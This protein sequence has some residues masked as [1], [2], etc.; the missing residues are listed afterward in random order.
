M[1]ISI[2]NYD[3]FKREYQKI[4]REFQF[5]PKEDQRARDILFKMIQSKKRHWKVEEILEEF[6]RKI[7]ENNA[8]LIYGCGPSLEDSVE[9][10]IASQG[11]SIFKRFINLAADGASVFLRERELPLEGIFTDL[12]G[13]TEKE[14]TYGEYLIVHAHGDNIDKLKSFKSHIIE[15]KNVIATTQVEPKLGVFNPGGFTDGDRILYFIKNLINPD[16]ILYLVGM[17]FKE[18]V[19][20]YSKPYKNEDFTASQIKRKKLQVA[21]ELI[22]QFVKEVENKIFFVNS[23]HVSDKFNYLSL[24]EFIT[25]HIPKDYMV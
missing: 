13:I 10:I 19:G 22:E 21:I 2:N 16:Q 11:K 5:E 14:F 12:D 25:E 17:D 15:K 20:K 24:S 3:S 18:T 6:K 1:K 9:K 7:E 4:V 23:P 8:L